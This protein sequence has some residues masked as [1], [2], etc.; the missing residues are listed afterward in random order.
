MLRTTRSGALLLALGLFAAL[1]VAGPRSLALQAQA[2]GH[3]P[4]RCHGITA[5]EVL[6]PRPTYTKVRLTPYAADDAVCRGIW[7]P[8]PRQRLVPQA[9]ALEG[10]TAWLVG[11]RWGERGERPCRL[12]RVDLRTGRRLAYQSRITGHV[13]TRPQNYCRHGGGVALA[14]HSLWITEKH[15]LWRYDPSKA[16]RSSAAHRVWRIDMPVR[17]STVVLSPD[18]TRI[19]LVP[20]MTGGKPK[21]HWYDLSAVTAPGVTDLVDTASGTKQIAPVSYRRI[22]TYVQ[23]A[24]FGPHGGLL[25][26]RSSTRCGELVTATGRRIAFIPGAEQLQIGPRGRRLWVVSESGAEPFQNGTRPM[27]PGLTAFAWP[28]VVHGPATGCHFS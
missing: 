19:G 18:R 12:Y 10:H 6:G 1:L 14:R 16:G 24:T 25:L 27:T 28:Q 26:T 3:V 23:G 13:G 11:Y 4:Q 9:L 15:K 2:H 20:F 7:L 5:R 22:P 21:I 17:G 8:R